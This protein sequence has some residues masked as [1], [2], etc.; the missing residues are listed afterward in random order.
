MVKCLSK[1]YLMTHMYTI[2]SFPDK[3]DN[4]RFRAYRDNIGG[5][6]EYGSIHIGTCYSYQPYYGVF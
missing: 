4:W 3:M 1:P 6:Y 2:A 5:P